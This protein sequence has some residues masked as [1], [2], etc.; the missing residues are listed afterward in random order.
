M[1]AIGVLASTRLDNGALVTSSS[2]ARAAAA[3]ASALLLPLALCL[4]LNSNRLGLFHRARQDHGR[5]PM[6]S[7]G[8]GLVLEIGVGGRCCFL[9]HLQSSTSVQL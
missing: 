1:K 5:Y 2:A 6:K 7:D 8:V 3:V 9:S 4:S